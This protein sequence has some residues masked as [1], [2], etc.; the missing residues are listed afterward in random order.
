[1]QEHLWK[2]RTLNDNLKS[3]RRGRDCTRKHCQEIKWNVYLIDNIFGVSVRT[4]SIIPVR[5]IY[6]QALFF[7]SPY[8]FKCVAILINFLKSGLFFFLKKFCFLKIFQRNVTDHYGFKYKLIDNGKREW[9][10]K[11]MADH[12]VINFWWNFFTK[13]H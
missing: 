11:N 12:Q 5:L 1:M 2:S 7:K 8:N 9:L 13:T 4:D 6:Y 10:S 3:V